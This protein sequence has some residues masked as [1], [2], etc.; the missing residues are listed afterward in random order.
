MVKLF[1]LGPPGSGKGTISN[2]LLSFFTLEDVSYY[3][4]GELLRSRAATDEHIRSVHAAGGLVDSNRVL[5]IFDNAL[6]KRSY[7]V[8]GS[9]RKL[10]EAQ[11]VLNHSKWKEDPGYLIHLDL[12]IEISRQRLKSRGRF[13]DLSDEVLDRRFK[14][15]VESTSRSIELFRQEGRLITVDANQLPKDVCSDI[16]C[17]LFKRHY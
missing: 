11:Y 13:D 8:D 1:I 6:S 5:G 2:I 12:D 3:N 9:P 16:T 7:I 10:E 17:E 14:E 15:F 4:V